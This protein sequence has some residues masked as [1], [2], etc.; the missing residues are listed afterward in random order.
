MGIKEELTDLDYMNKN[1]KIAVN[2]ET[3]LK[4]KLTDS[5]QRAHIVNTRYKSLL[6]SSIWEFNLEHRLGK[7]IFLNHLVDL[8]FWNVKRPSGYIFILKHFG[9]QR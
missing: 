6:P 4:T 9:D 8:S 7:G 2:F 3:S 1:N 5:L